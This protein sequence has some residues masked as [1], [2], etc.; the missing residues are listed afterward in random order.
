M[1]R[2]IQTVSFKDSNTA[3]NRN[4]NVT[5][6]CNCYYDWEDIYWRQSFS[7][8]NEYNINMMIEILY[9]QVAYF[10]GTGCLK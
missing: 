4:D 6:I 5:M 7:A 10:S 1:I 9:L 2:R 3:I 8:I